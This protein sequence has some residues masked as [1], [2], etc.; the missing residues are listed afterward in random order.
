MSKRSTSQYEQSLAIRAAWL[1]YVAGLKQSEV[2][3]RLGVQTLK[4][5]RLIAKAGSI[6][7]VKVTIEGDIDQCIIL[8]NKLRE[9]FDLDICEVAPDL[10]EE[11]MP[12]QALG[13]AGASRIRRWVD[14]REY[15]CIGIGHGRTLSAAVQALPTTEKSDVTFVSLLGGLTRNFAANPHDVMHRLAKR[16]NAKA[17]VMP[18]PFF[19]NSVKDRE[20]LLAQTPVKTV[21]EMAK[22]AP[23]KVVGIGEVSEHTQLVK[24]GMIEVSEI[25]DIA[26]LGGRGEV[27]G[28]FF[29]EDGRDVKT[30]LTAR[31]LAASVGER[32]DHCIVA[33]AG[34]GHKIEAIRAVLKSGKISGL[35]TDELTAMSLISE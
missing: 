22:K 11:G 25:D 7:A 35:I 29:D 5:H 33:L 3:K 13:V 9:T 16:L 4:A 8:E 26:R 27:L 23:L 24:S 18:V 31:T 6:G 15:S 21:F 14:S 34:G 12:L 19:A 32:S 17:Y 10:G 1:H 2:A 28:H 20:V 30:A